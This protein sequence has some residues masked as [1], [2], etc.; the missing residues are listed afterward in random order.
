VAAAA[1]EGPFDALFACVKS[2]DVATL[3]DQVRFAPGLGSPT[4]VVFANGIGP[5]DL[6]ASSLGPDRVVRGVVHFA[7]AL[8]GTGRSR[9]SFLGDPSVVGGMNDASAREAA[10]VAALLTAAGIETAVVD[11]IRSHVWRKAVL[12]AILAPLCAIT[13]LDMKAAL[14][15]PVLARMSDGLLTECIE[16]ARRLGHDWGEGFAAEARRYVESAGAHRPSMLA[17]VLEGRRTE[18]AFLNG[19]IVEEADRLGVPAPLNRMVTALLSA[20]DSIIADP[21]GA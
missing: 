4:V 13:R 16:V 10:V 2:T 3:V 21:R 9:I 1:E 7:A 17:D 14:Q 5:E 6:V 15:V 11:D 8:E 12:V 20:I 19:V 18:V